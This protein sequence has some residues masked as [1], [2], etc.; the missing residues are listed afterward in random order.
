MPKQILPLTDMKIQKTKPQEIPITLFDGGGLYI[1]ITPAGGRLWRLKYRHD[2]KPKLMALGKYPE[3]SLEEARDRRE[4]AKKL[5]ANGTDPGAVKQAQ[6]TQTVQ[7]KETFEVVAREWFEKH[8]PV[9]AESHASRIIRRLELNVFPYIGNTPINQITSPQLLSVL[10]RIEDRG[11]IGTAHRIKEICGQVFRYGVATGRAERNPTA[12]LQGALQ[13]FKRD[14]MPAITNPS[15]AGDLLRATDTYR[16]SFVVQCALK[17][18]P[19]VFVRPGE[20]RKAEWAEIDLEHALW[21]IPAEKMKMKQAHIVPLST[22]AMTI[23]K[24]IHPLTG[25]GKH[26]F[27]GRTS[28]RPMSDNAILA[29]LRNMGFEKT[30]MT[31]HGFR[32]MARTMLDEVLHEP[33]HLIEH[34]LAHTVKDPL[35]RAYN[36]TSH[37]PERTAMMQRWA[38]YLD[39]LKQGAVV[40]PFKQI[41][42]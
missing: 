3:V 24:E 22:Q 4:Q 2:N 35:G 15:R 34:Q 33:I 1:L 6:K 20:L 12:D 40:L 16:G 30:E 42:Q 41:A 11:V 10:R 19:L 14:H 25:S 8:K 17:L 23:L 38:D 28:D 9:W 5:L 31:G 7:E 21:N 37:L 18:A 32:A 29:A 39:G 13:P 26:V 36:R 27:P